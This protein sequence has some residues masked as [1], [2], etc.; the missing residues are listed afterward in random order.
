VLR[1]VEPVESINLK[2]HL[3][4]IVTVRRDTGDILLASQ[5]ALPR[6]L[7]GG[8]DLQLAA[9][10]EP[11]LAEGPEPIEMGQMVDESMPMFEEEGSPHYYNDGFDEGYSEGYSGGYGEGY[12]GEY[13]EGID[14]GGCDSCGRGVPCRRGGACELA[15]LAR[16]AWST[17][18][19]S[20]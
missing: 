6:T 2:S 3:G 8:S 10:A 17:S 18:M 4:K 15:G 20:T 19:A 16:G 9:F 13:D 1:Y 12:G 14:F 5:L 11:T 7:R